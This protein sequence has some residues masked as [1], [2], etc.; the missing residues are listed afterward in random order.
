MSISF[1]FWCSSHFYQISEKVESGEVAD[2]SLNDWS[3]DKN[4]APSNA[5]ALQ[6]FVLRCF[7]MKIK[8][9]MIFCL[10]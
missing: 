6:V 2:A 5:K 3:K 8:S 4:L 10:I 1:L 9:N 7:E